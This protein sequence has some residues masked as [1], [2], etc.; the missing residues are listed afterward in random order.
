MEEGRD[1]GFHDNTFMSLLVLPASRLKMPNTLPPLHDVLPLIS[2]VSSGGQSA[3]SACV[4]VCVCAVC[5][6]TV[7]LTVA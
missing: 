6:I 2:A 4:H 5:E 7:V 3:V 1:L